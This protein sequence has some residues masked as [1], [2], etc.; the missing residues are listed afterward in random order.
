M[1]INTNKGSSFQQLQ[2]IERA[3]K[4]EINE[5]P[6]SVR[7]TMILQHADVRLSETVAGHFVPADVQND[8]D[9]AQQLQ[10]SATPRNNIPLF[11]T[12]YDLAQGTG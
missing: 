11:S 12:A 2:P 6:I 1:A 7:P 3:T 10:T 9:S 5:N 4:K 8:N